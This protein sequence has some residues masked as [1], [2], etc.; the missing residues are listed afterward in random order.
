MA[1]TVCAFPMLSRTGAGSSERGASGRVIPVA[2]AS[3]ILVGGFLVL[4]A[5][6]SPDAGL[7]PLVAARLTTV[8]IFAVILAARC[9]GWP[10]AA[11]RPAVVS[12]VLDTIANIG[13]FVSV[14]LGALAIVATIVSLAPAVSVLLA[15]FVLHERWTPSQRAG[16]VLIR[17]DRVRL[18]GLIGP[19]AECC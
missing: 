11:S 6:V 5:R 10:R 16:L 14:H 19:G 13:Y 15:R 7:G 9:H 1:L 17:G 18:D 4:I 2:I 3:G 8:A 12:G